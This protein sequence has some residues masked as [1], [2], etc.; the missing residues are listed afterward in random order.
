MKFIDADHPFFAP[1]WRRWATVILPS[2]WA[3]VEYFWTGNL[4]WVAIF[5]GLGVWAGYELIVKGPAQP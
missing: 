1:V 5:A 2:L 3:G 4:T